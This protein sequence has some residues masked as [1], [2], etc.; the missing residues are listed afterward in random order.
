[1]CSQ[2]GRICMDQMMVDVTDLPEVCLGDPAVVIGPGP[3]L[4]AERLA[5]NL[6]TIVYEV[7]CDLG[8]R[9]ERKYV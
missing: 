1:M 9:L 2:V 4:S 7:L 8:R 3:G 5:E 6:G